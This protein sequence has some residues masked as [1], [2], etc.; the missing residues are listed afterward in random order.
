MARSGDFAPM[1]ISVQKPIVN[2]MKLMK[3]DRL[4]IFTDG[5]RS[6]LDNEKEPEI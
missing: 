3:R 1:E 4:R 6:Y 2:A 5:N